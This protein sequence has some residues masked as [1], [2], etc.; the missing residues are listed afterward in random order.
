MAAIMR[1]CTKWRFESITSRQRRAVLF[2]CAR[3]LD[4]EPETL[5]YQVC[6]QSTVLRARVFDPSKNQKHETS[7]Q[8]ILPEGLL[9]LLEKT[10]RLPFSSAPFSTM[11]DHVPPTVRWSSCSQAF[12]TPQEGGGRCRGG[13]GMRGS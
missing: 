1:T 7:R 5:L 2:C 12:L 10:L 11:L 9:A 6:S 4:I 8:I 3:G 13:M